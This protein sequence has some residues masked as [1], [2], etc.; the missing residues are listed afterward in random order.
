MLENRHSVIR[1]KPYIGSGGQ[2][3]DTMY[4]VELYENKQLVEERELPGKSKHYADSVSENWG[5]GILNYG[6]KS[7]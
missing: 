1:R 5:E 2:G 3:P 7:G 6:D 4:V